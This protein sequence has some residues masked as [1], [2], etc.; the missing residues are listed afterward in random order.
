M[1]HCSKDYDTFYLDQSKCEPWELFPK[2]DDAC[3]FLFCVYFEHGV[4]QQSAI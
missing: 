1:I 3:V 4:K 2:F